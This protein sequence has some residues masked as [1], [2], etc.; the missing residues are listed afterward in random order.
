MRGSSEVEQRTHNPQAVGSSPTPATKS[1]YP[2]GGLVRL[3]RP[4]APVEERHDRRDTVRRPPSSAAHTAPATLPNDITGKPTISRET[5]PLSGPQAVIYRELRRAADAGE[6]IPQYKRL[7]ELCGAPGAAIKALAANGFLR[8]E[9]SYADRIITIIATGQRLAARR[10]TP[11]PPKV[12]PPAP[13]DLAEIIGWLND[14]GV[15]CIEIRGIGG[16]S[17]MLG[18]NYVEAR[19]VVARA[20]AMR[21]ARKLPEFILSEGARRTVAA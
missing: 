6:T 14:N 20:N 16:A 3:A 4:P 21:R 12:T 1:E 2:E 17:F 18:E 5:S 11:A 15:D 19:N 8:V 7:T 10:A 13:V 9:G